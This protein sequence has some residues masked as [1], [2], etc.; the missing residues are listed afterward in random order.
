MKGGDPTQDSAATA[1]GLR[2]L[3]IAP[4]PRVSIQAFCEHQQTASLIQSAIEDRRMHKAHVKIHMGGAA[5]AVEAY[6]EA[7]TPNVI[8]IEGSENRQA[9]IQHLDAL[10]QFCD[11]GTKVVALGRTNDIMLYRD[12]ISRGVSEYL[13]EPY[14]VLQFVRAI[15]DLYAAPG[16]DPLGRVVAVYGAKGG[17]GSSTV[18]H[19]LGWAI[20]GD[21][22][23]ATVIVD[24]D[25][26]YGTC[27][28]DFN[29]DPPQ[30]I[31]EAVYA[32]DRLDA[33]LVDKLL[34]K[35]TDK[36][37]ILAAPATL[38]RSYDFDETSFDSL[39]D[40]LRATVPV[41]ILDIPHVFTAWSRRMLVAADEVV[42]VA[43]PDLGN[44]RNTKNMI[45]AL[46]TV[47]PNDE[48]PRLVMNMVGVPKR[49]E[50]ALPDFTRAVGA[51]A[52]AIV[53]FDPKLFGTA[54]NNGQMIAEIEA[55][56]KTAETFSD[57]ARLVT[58]RTE[59]KRARRGLMDSLLS[60]K[61]LFSL[62]KAS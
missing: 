42:L 6:R 39:I 35:C 46:T 45:E 49:P 4:V 10:A 20:S 43:S 13:V 62:G 26:A 37:S 56:G 32:P 28:L 31:A 9:L 17:V 30:T 54:G 29:Q 11:A 19:N 55:N 24:L 1:G 47:R 27:G 59:V 15:S 25:L 57:L 23:I 8:V 48:R 16:S 61:S 5:A 33:N 53:S 36:L 58:G 44:L 38:E 3:Q 2:E 21:L 7:P 60:G 14:D 51:E 22:D 52:S 18:A 34:S 40:V 41:V 12:L 50:I